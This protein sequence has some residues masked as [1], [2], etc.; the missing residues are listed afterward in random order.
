MAEEVNSRARAPTANQLSASNTQGQPARSFS[1]IELLVALTIRAVLIALILP[2]MQAAGGASYANNLD[3]RLGS[4]AYGCTLA[5]RVQERRARRSDRPTHRRAS[6]R[7]SVSADRSAQRNLR[8]G[9]KATPSAADEEL[10]R[11]PSGRRGAA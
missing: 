5:K 11:D 9:C 2:A 3:G 6:L 8:F 4:A 1:F 7:A 10:L